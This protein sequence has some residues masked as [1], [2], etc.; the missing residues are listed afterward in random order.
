MGVFLLNE[1]RQ[2]ER[3]EIPAHNA[4]I[5]FPLA[6]VKGVTDVPENVNSVYLPTNEEI[7][8][9][10]DGDDEVRRLEITGFRD[11]TVEEE[12]LESPT[13]SLW[14]VLSVGDALR[15]RGMPE[16]RIDDRFKVNVLERDQARTLS[17][18]L[19]L[20]RG[21]I[22]TTQWIRYDDTSYVVWRLRPEIESNSDKDH[23]QFAASVVQLE[24]RIPAKSIR[25][26]ARD[27]RREAERQI[28]ELTPGEN[29][30]IEI[31]VLNE[32]S[33]EI[34]DLGAPGK[35][36]VGVVRGQDKIF[37]SVLKL[38]AEPPE[39]FDFPVPIAAR[40]LPPRD[41]KRRRDGSVRSAYPCSPIRVGG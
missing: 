24:C 11:G 30:E 36:E 5:R 35:I 1:S 4:A 40:L 38:L 27:L 20:T 23:M 3:K 33:D 14:W 26:M 7:R 25:I 29:G 6:R 28:V 39:E 16:P 13:E 37:K 10:F 22:K 2:G 8:F 34:L 21:R 32:E 41:P 15:R 18:R 17:A 19:L 31:D 9:T 12:P